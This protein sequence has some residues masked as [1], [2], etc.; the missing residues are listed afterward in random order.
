[1]FLFLCKLRFAQTSMTAIKIES[2][3]IIIPED[4]GIII[5]RICTKITNKKIE[6]PTS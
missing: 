1:M 5:F 2:V 6:P 3:V 4:C